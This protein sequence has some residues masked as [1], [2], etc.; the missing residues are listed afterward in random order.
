MKII[1]KTGDPN[2]A[3]VY[4]AQFRGD[5]NLLIEFVDSRDPNLPKNEK[6]VII[7]STQFG[8][9]VEC[10]MCDSGGNYRGDLTSEEIFAQIDHV[11]GSYPEGLASH[12]KKFKIQFA[13]M[14]E[15]ALNQAVLDVI[16]ELP[17]RYDNSNIIPCI[18]TTAPVSASAWFDELLEIK[19]SIYA[20]KLFQLQF[21]INS[22][23]EKER[24][25]LM[26]VL[27]WDLP[28]IAEYGNRFVE[29][30]DRKVSLNFALT[31]GVTVD[32]ETISQHFDPKKICIKITPLNPTET[33][34]ESG[35]KNAIPAA[36]NII[37]ELT[38]KGFD[39]ILSIGE[40]KENQ[41]GSN[42]GQAVKKL[43][44]GQII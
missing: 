11:V 29:N 3:E 42:C 12:C 4:V 13:R 40:P 41:I 25:R 6:W 22:T 38:Q 14:G 9:P 21:S 39:T 43:V 26:P 30:G 24:D 32:A 10:L 31:E 34:S 37:R 20:G 23:D 36:E 35:L 1:S 33:A 44:A 16:R 2:I 5:K 19:K 17:N 18:A 28:Q 15:P 27:K 7:V 8:C